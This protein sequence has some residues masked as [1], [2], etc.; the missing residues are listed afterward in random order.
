MW[1]Q[2]FP[3]AEITNRFAFVLY[4]IEG[5]VC[6]LQTAIDLR[7]KGYNVYI[8]VEGVSSSR[9]LDRSTGLRRMESEGCKLNTYEGIMME[10]QKD[11]SGKDF[12]PF[13]ELLK[14]KRPDDLL[15]TL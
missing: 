7:E 1:P 14:E 13:L 10:L 11:I 9:P 2:V 15:D 3:F 6:V 4:G 12:K 5:H 8:P